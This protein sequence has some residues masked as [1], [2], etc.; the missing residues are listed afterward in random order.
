MNDLIA[1]FRVGDEAAV[2]AVHRRYGGAVRTIARS[3]MSEDDLIAE[4]VQQTFIK[5][6]RSMDSFEDG[7]DF[8]PWL[9]TIARRTAIDVLRKEKRP[10]T[11]DHEPEVDVEGPSVSFEQTWEKLEVR[12]AIAELPEAERDVVRLS[13]LVGLTHPEIAEHLGVPVG[14]VKSR[15][16]RA[17]KR[18]YSALQHLQL[19]ANQ[20]GV[21]AVQ[22]HEEP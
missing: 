4:V 21:S 6:W 3:M 13:H 7:R 19:P 8:A 1:Q 18:L 9:Y 11:G 10:T 17:N 16:G 5:A 15:S 12:R 14:T 2:R 20:T 22:G